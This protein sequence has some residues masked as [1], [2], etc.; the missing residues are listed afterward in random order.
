MKQHIK[1]VVFPTDICS[2]RKEGHLMK[3][4]MEKTKITKID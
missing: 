1:F 3:A 4:N 2:S